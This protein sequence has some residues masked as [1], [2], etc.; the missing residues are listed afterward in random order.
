MTRKIAISV[1]DD[2]AARLDRER[3]VSAFIAET[4]RQRM[5]G[6]RVRETLRQAGFSVTVEGVEQAGRELDELHRRVTP[7]L[8]REAAAL[9]ARLRSG[10]PG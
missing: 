5:T 8:R 1:P 4:I 7:R 3:N 2:V 6:E 9:Q 10:Q